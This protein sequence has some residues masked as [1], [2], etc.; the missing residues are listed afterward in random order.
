VIA[1]IR[2]TVKKLGSDP[3]TWNADEKADQ[4]VYSSVG[5]VDVPNMPW[6]NRP[7]FQQVVEAT[8]HR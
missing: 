1:S 5:V 7:T 8:S 4:I 6:Q 3:D 2:A